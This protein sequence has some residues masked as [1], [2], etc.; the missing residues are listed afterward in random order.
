MGGED[1]RGPAHL[2]HSLAFQGQQR[3]VLDLLP[4]AQP[5]PAD[6]GAG[7]APA[8]ALQA[9]GLA[10]LHRHGALGHHGNRGGLW[11]D[12]GVRE[13]QAGTDCGVSGAVSWAP[14]FLSHC[15]PCTMR[16]TTLLAIPKRL[17][18]TQ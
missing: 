12:G 13:G 11:G 9:E 18:A 8:E 14:G 7:V 3:L 4:H 16:L 2:Q 1:P 5:A 6:Q 17:E 10:H 15:S